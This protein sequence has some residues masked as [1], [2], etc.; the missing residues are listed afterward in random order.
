MEARTQ[1]R[2]SSVRGR[3]ADPPV[4]ASVFLMGLFL[5]G[6]TGGGLWALQP[7]VCVGL[8]SVHGFLAMAVAL[9]LGLYVVLGRQE[10]VR[11]GTW[12]VISFTVGVLVFSLAVSAARIAVQDGDVILEPTVLHGVPAGSRANVG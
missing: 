9:A 1:Q 8:C 4:P 5:G 3:S 11:A 12:F 10:G 2:G 6:L 7:Q